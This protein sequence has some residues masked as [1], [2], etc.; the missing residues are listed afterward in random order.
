MSYEDWLEL[1]DEYY[2]A[3]RS[4]QWFSG[5]NYPTTH[6]GHHCLELY[7]KAIC[8]KATNEYNSNQHDLAM[9]FEDAKAHLPLIDVKEV[10][11]AIEKYRHYDIVARYSSKE[12]KSKQPLPTNSSMGSDS[13]H[14]LDAS[15]AVLRD[16]SV[17]TRRGIDRLIEGET[18]FSKMG[19]FEP[20]LSLHS[21]ILFHENRAFTPKRPEVKRQVNY[22]APK[23]PDNR[24]Y[25]KR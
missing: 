25:S 11:I 22:S 21:V 12:L 3:A 4:L 6:A 16:I 13:L 10:R 15:V 9:L 18:D 19:L 20:Y 24:E 8:V 1:A 23:W 7:L 14:S 5:L 2:L 17:K